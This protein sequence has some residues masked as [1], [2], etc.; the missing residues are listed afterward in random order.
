MWSGL[1][2]SAI[3]L[4]MLLKAFDGGE[5]LVF[6]IDETIERR[7]GDK[8][9]AKGIYRDRVRSSKGHFVKA[10]GLRW[11]CLMGLTPIH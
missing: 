5:P 9:R 4:R 2:A 11:L 3:L 8:I 6:G 1:E 10:S 7:R